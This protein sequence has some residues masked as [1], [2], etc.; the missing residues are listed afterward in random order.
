MSVAAKRTVATSITLEPE[1]YSQ[2]KML[3]EISGYRFSFSGFVAD[4]LREKIQC[5]QIRKPSLQ[6][7]A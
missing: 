5:Q 6:Q 3:A 1:L 7:S 2:A 4:V